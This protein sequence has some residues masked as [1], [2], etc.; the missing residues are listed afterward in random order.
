MEVGLP[1]LAGVALGVFVTLAVGAALLRRYSDFSQLVS[2][3]Y[4]KGGD[5]LALEAAAS[6]RSLMPRPDEGGLM[7][8]SPEMP[9][10]PSS[11]FTLLL[12]PRS[13]CEDVPLRGR[14]WQGP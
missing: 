6:P 8:Q 11:A 9:E 14:G 13:P 7:P 4:E 1:I 3:A 5:G 2:P 12:S 10:T